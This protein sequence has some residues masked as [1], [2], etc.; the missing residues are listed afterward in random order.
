[1]ESVVPIVL[2]PAVVHFPIALLLL[3]LALTSAYLHWRDPFYDRA[4]YGVLVLGWWAAFAAIVTGTLEV[5]LLW[6]L[7]STTLGWIN[8]HAVSG[9][10]LLVVYGQAL[11]RRRR[12][13]RILD[14]PDRRGY[15]ALLVFGA[16]LVLVSGWIG[17]HLVYSL[18]VGVR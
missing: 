3:N 18:G 16:L 17:G 14:G 8:A 7:D 10:V 13:P 12:N 1:L 4:A 5:A 15:I 11:L 9:L 2:H 6:P